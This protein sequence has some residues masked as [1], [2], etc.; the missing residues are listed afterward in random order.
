VGKLGEGRGG[1]PALDGRL[2]SGRFQEQVAS[3]ASSVP[4]QAN[5][6]H[7]L[8]WAGWFV[9]ILVLS[10]LVSLEST[11]WEGLFLAH[12][13]EAV[14]LNRHDHTLAPSLLKVASCTS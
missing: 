3:Q 11:L 14:Y 13:A 7:T 2:S 6:H 4:A 5:T 10:C 12:A 8:R 9:V 1:I